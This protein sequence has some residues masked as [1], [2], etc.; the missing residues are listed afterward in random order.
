L[1]GV[2]SDLSIVKGEF[3]EGSFPETKVLQI[4]SFKI[5]L[6]HGHQ[7]RLGTLCRMLHVCTRL[8]LKDAS[9]DN[10]LGLPGIVD[11]IEVLTRP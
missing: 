11:G 4:G 10:R 3:D 5:G 6:C 9:V 8:H 1:K 7:V 2:C